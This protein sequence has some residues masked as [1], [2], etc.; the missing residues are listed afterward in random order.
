MRTTKGKIYRGSYIENVAFNPSLSPLQ[1]ALA[2]I[3]AAR[4]EYSAISAVRLIERQ[5]AKISQRYV[6]EIVL[7]AVAPEAKLDVVEAG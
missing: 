5:R 3:I 7:R 1:V 6:T 2:A 4:E